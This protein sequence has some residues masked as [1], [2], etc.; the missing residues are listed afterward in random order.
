MFTKAVKGLKPLRLVLGG[1]SG[2]G[3]SKTALIF[4]TYLASLSGKPTAAVDTEHGRLSLY[5]DEFQFD[6]IEA[7]PPFHPNNL[8]KLIHQAEDAGYGQMVVDSS[9]HFYRG[10]GGLLEIVQ[11]A[12]K[13]RFNGN[14]YY[15]WQVGTPIYEALIDTIIRSPMH[16]ILTSRSNQKYMEEEQQGKKSYRKVGEQ[17]QQREGW[18]YEFDF[19]LLMDMDHTAS[20]EKGLNEVDTSVYFKMPNK[21]AIKQIMDALQ[22][23]SIKKPDDIKTLKREVKR[24]VEEASPELKEK[25]KALFTEVGNPN[26]ITDTIVMSKLISQMKEIK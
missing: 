12:A 25:Y 7:E 13:N 4:A 1:P 20:V 23:D 19:A 3:K 17:L 11:E 26:E 6:V 2:S 18:E 15:A 21:D 24:L 22:K 10:T 16:V 9:T 8:I 5:A 14:T